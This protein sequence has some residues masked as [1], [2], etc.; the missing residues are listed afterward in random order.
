MLLE[1]PVGWS[2]RGCLPI[3]IQQARLS[4]NAIALSFRANSLARYP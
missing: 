4:G 3:A 2:L 1:G